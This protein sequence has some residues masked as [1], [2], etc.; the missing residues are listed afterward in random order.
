MRDRSRPDRPLPDER[1]VVPARPDTGGGAAT[2]SF[3]LPLDAS[4]GLPGAPAPLAIGPA[5]FAWGSRT[6]VMGVLNV[7]PDSFSGDGLLAAPDPVASAV[8]QARRMVDAG[9]DI[10]DVGGASSRPGHAPVP[11]DEEAARV[12]PVIRALVAKLPGTPLSIDTTS[13][14]VA[15]AALDAGAHLL[16]DIWG[17]ADDDA[18]IRLA[19][20]RAIPIVLMHNRAE[21]R[22]RNLV[23]EVI[24]DLQRALDRALD[25]GVPWEHLVVD[26]GFGFG[27]TPDHNLALLADLA[28][29]AVLGRPILLGT[30]R[31]S[32][33]GRLLDLPPDQRAEATAATTAL[34]I[35]AGVDVVR[36]HDVL[37]NV[38]TA[39]V[40]DA[41]VRG[42]R[43][44]GWQGAG[45]GR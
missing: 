30:S 29:L 8:A 9:A 14:A 18:M 34:G 45:G 4:D 26:P 41:V 22:Y 12:V 44:D 42:W 32:T 39:R 11:P 7:T 31:K 23:P 5:T 27:K 35:A 16:N 33:L 28:A 2:P 21:A 38:R 13:P 37:E 20:E 17:V 15:A 19:A 10:L 6:F 25:A 43:P 36:V 1:G 3:A 40:A 24:A